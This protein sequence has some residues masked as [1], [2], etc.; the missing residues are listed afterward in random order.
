MSLLCTK[1]DMD[2]IHLMGRFRSDEMLRYLHVQSFPLV[3]YLE[4][5]ML[6]NGH[7]TMMPSLPL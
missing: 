6:Q 2:M 7:Y 1:V 4:S 3:T 5:Q